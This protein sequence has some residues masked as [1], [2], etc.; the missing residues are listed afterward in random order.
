VS[1]Q[2]EISLNAKFS[3]LFK[4]AKGFSDEDLF[5]LSQTA[6]L[7]CFYIHRLP[8]GT[9]NNGFKQGQVATFLLNATIGVS[10]H[11]GNNADEF[12]E[13]VMRFCKDAMKQGL[14]AGISLVRNTHQM[15]FN[16]QSTLPTLDTLNFN[17]SN[18]VLVWLSIV[19]FFTV[20]N[21]NDL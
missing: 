10:K 6:E 7:Y 11:L 13:V 15:F 16:V 21:F 19:L 3:E 20:Y 2:E 8:A 17:F 4:L 1:G 12:N 14:K 18:T 9:K 5:F